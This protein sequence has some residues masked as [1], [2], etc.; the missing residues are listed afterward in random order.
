MMKSF[1]VQISGQSENTEHH[2]HRRTT[3]RIF[4]DQQYLIRVPTQHRRKTATKNFP[5]LS[6][7]T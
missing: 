2:K 1:S 5:D 3:T 7:D 6:L 4:H